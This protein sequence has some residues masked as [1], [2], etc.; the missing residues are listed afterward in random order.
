MHVLS[1]R[2]GRVLTVSSQLQA[3]NCVLQLTTEATNLD[4]FGSDDDARSNAEDG[5]ALSA[6]QGILHEH[7]GTISSEY[8][9]DGAVLLRMEL[10]ALDAVPAKPK[11]AT[12]P[13]LWQSRPF[14]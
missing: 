6:C 5:L 13:V 3:G 9:P 10:P 14:A 8:H 1:E 4:G 2:G 12:V 7:R 11:D